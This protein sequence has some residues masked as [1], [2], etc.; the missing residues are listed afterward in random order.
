MAKLG[1]IALFVVLLTSE[2][3][4]QGTA[5]SFRALAG[6]WA[7]GGTIRMVS[8]ASE[9]I[10]CRA[11]YVVGSGAL[12]LQQDLLCASDSFRFQIRTQVARQD[13]R[14]SG[15]WIEISRNIS[16]SLAGRIVNGRI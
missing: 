10:R 4:A 3:W 12:V 16:G 5:S 7:G 13:K 6:Q 2:C 8:G 9:R 14:L 11:T 1:A 15:N